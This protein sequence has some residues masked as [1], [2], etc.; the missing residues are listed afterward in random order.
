M[1]FLYLIITR[2]YN[3]NT[4]YEY[5][6]ENHFRKFRYFYIRYFKL[7]RKFFNANFVIN[8]IINKYSYIIKVINCPCTFCIE[9]T[10]NCGL[11]HTVKESFVFCNDI[12]I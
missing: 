8:S 10:Y 3:S 9:Y 11:Q 4:G 5:W 6:K 12:A 1:F 7:Q 2:Y